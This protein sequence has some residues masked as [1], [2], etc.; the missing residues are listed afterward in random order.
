MQDIA[1]VTGGKVVSEETGMKLESAE[2][3]VLGKARKIISSKDNTIIVGGKGKKDEIEKRVEQVRTQIA[4]ADSE[5]D[6]E[7][8][9]ERLAKLCGGAAVIKVGAATETEMKYKKMKIEDAVEATKAAIEEGIVPGGGTAFIKA[10]IM[11]YKDFK[12][13]KLKSL[14]KDIEKEFEA[15]IMIL[16][17]AIEEPIRQI[18]S[19]SG[20]T[21]GAVV[22]AEIKESATKNPASNKGYDANS[23]KIISD[24]IKQGIIDPVK[25]TRA[26]LQNAA[27]AAAMFLTTEAAVTDIP[28]EKPGGPLAGGQ[29]MEY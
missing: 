7:K 13:G 4:K 19:N 2:L 23:D 18:V 9:R 3:S 16:L 8:L 24:M 17:R 25:V 20:K 6:R 26:A 14:S 15:G 27:S 22:V 21:E 5:F 11:V 10:E 28:K 1:A 12:E 29:G